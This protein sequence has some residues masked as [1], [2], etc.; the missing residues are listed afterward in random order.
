M[1][2]GKTTVGRELASLLGWRFVDLD[3]EIVAREGRS[4]ARIFQSE[5][6]PHF[7]QIESELLAEVLRSS[8]AAVIAL[9]GGTFIQPANRK[10]LR[11][12]EALI[13][14]LDGDFELLNA[15]CCSEDGVRPLMQDPVHFRNLFE[16]RRP[17]YRS[18]EIVVDIAGKAPQA[19]AAEILHQVNHWKSRKA[20]SE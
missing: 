17:I 18:A 12:H 8:P 3:A 13:A 14:H 6:E 11:S 4:I 20:V 2:S 1:G 16:Q 19:I 15:R 5:G 7:R 10:L 9:G